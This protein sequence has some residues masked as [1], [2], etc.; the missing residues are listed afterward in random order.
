MNVNIRIRGDF[1]KTYCKEDPLEHLTIVIGTFS[2]VKRKKTLFVV[3]LPQVK[4]DGSGFEN[5]KVA[6]RTICYGRN[7][8]VGI[9]LDEPWLF[10]LVYREV[11]VSL[12]TGSLV[13]VAFWTFITK[14]LLIFK[15][16]LG[17]E[18]FQED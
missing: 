4:Q 12:T 14:H 8:T 10:C 9:Y 2:G 17:L 6:S 7:A 5:I 1:G 16:I 18:F 11:E 13:A 15:P 3:V